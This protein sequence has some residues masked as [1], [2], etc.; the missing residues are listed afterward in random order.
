MPNHTTIPSARHQNAKPL[1]NKAAPSL[2][3][4]IKNMFD[5]GLDPTYIQ[6]TTVL[7]VKLWLPSCPKVIKSAM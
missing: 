2:Q 3:S 1:Q 6:S 7:V 5:P 4:W